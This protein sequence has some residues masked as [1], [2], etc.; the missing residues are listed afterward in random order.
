MTHSHTA[1]HTTHI[2]RTSRQASMHARNTPSHAV[3]RSLPPA[4]PDLLHVWV[5]VWQQ[6]PLAASDGLLLA[7]QKGGRAKG[8]G[9]AKEEAGVWLGSTERH[10]VGAR[11]SSLLGRGWTR[12]GRASN[13]QHTRSSAHPAAYI[14]WADRQRAWPCTCAKQRVMNSPPPPGPQPAAAAAHMPTCQGR[15]EE[16]PPGGGGC[17]HPPTHPRCRHSPWP[18]PPHGPPQPQLR[19]APASLPRVPVGQSPVPWP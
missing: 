17:S 16:K 19:A 7:G 9:A 4:R 3:P 18:L 1:T 2:A 13:T 11:P 10:T 12:Q 8:G 14:M 6:S 15:N 5:A